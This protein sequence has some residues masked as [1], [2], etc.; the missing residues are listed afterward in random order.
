[1]SK[2]SIDILQ[3][4]IGLAHIVIV[5]VERGIFSWGDNSYGQ[6]GHGDL[7]ARE[8]PTEIVLLRGKSIVK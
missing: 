6:L 2:S 5:S 8:H 7:E 1:M 3:V 4:S